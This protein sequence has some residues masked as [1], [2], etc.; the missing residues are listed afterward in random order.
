ML[1]LLPLVLIPAPST[2]LA[3]GCPPSMCGTTS[4]AMPG[5]RTL[6]VR[7]WGQQG[8]LRAFDLVSGARRY[9][10]PP[11]MLSANGRAFVASARAKSRRTTVV[12]YDAQTGRLRSGRSLPG[13]WRVAGLSANGD[14]VALME[15][16]KRATVL[17][18]A[19]S[20][21]VLR[22]NYEVEALSPDGRRVFLVHW[23]RSGAYDLQQLDLASNRL[24]PT[25]LD[26][27]D[28]KMTGTATSAVA[29]RDGR[30]LLT[31]YSTGNGSFVHALDLRSGLGHC[32][33]LPLAGD[34]FA[35]GSTALTLSPQQDRLYLA[36]PYL[37]RVMTVDLDRLEVSR[38]V[39]FRGLST[40]PADVSIGPSGAVTANGRM[41]AFSG[42][43]SLWLYDTAYGIVRRPIRV[44]S[45][46]KGLGF[47]PDGR[48]VVAIRRSSTAVSFDAATGARLRTRRGAGS[49][50][51]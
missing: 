46:T 45:T 38:D 30:W 32:I 26:D 8:P 23:R 40:D 28:E 13:R 18:V 36:S 5:S 20:R 22:G 1:L 19:G 29:T 33:D 7:P 39:R 25:R 2:A 16:R 34:L 50:A 17:E 6:F 43:T 9:S 3:D 21:S 11:G 27:P 42:G 35:V 47:R 24:S 12:R 49:T 41:L 48:A 44:G 10:F 37:G 51:P 31:L 15:Y 4:A 14:R